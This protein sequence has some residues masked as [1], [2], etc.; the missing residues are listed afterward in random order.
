[1][2]L[3]H[4]A[5]ARVALPWKNGGGTTQEV[6]ASPAGSSFDTFNWRVSLAAVSRAGPFSQ[7]AGIERVMAVIA[8]ELAFTLADEPAVILSRHSAPLRFAGET[9]ARAEPLGGAVRDLNLMTRRGRCSGELTRHALGCT[10]ALAPEDTSVIM[11][12]AHARL[13]AGGQ[14]HALAPFDAAELTQV[15]ACELS[16]AAAVAGDIYV[17]RITSGATA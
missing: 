16:A 13:R 15:T 9:P 4:R 12:L 7:F 8:G 5:A 3:I 14:V 17:A 11:T 2:V 1:V 10:L 6:I